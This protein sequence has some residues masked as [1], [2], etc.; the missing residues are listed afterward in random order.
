MSNKYIRAVYFTRV[1]SL[2]YMYDLALVGVKCS[3]WTYLA[4]CLWWR[5]ARETDPAQCPRYHLYITQDTAAVYRVLFLHR[6]DCIREFVDVH[7]TRSLTG[8]RHGR[9]TLNTRMTLIRAERGMHGEPTQ[10]PRREWRPQPKREPSPCTLPLPHCRLMCSMHRCTAS[11]W[12]HSSSIQHYQRCDD[13]RSV[14]NH[15]YRRQTE[16]TGRDSWRRAA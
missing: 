4:S 1:D 10:R 14:L 11:T 16:R 5:W 12:L 6:R 2:S 8:R 15:T 13:R 3:S 7:N 9:R